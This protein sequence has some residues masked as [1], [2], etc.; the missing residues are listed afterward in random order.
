M[1][2]YLKWTGTGLALFVSAMLLLAPGTYRSP[3]NNF[4]AA[5]PA[6]TDA[7]YD[8]DD[9]IRA[10]V[11]HLDNAYQIEH[12][13][14]SNDPDASEDDFGR[15]DYITLKEQA[16]KPDLSSSTDR[17]GVYVKSDGLYIEQDDGTEVKIFDFS[18]DKVNP[19]ALS[20]IPASAME[21]SLQAA[22]VPS[23]AVM[24]Y[25]QSTVPT[26]WLECNGQAVS[27]TTYSD[28]FTA[29]GVTY[30]DGDGSTTFNVPD[31]RGYF[32]RGWSH[33]A[34]VDP[35]KASRT[36]RGDGTT[37]DNVGTK[38]SD[39]FK[40]HDHTYTASN[41]S[42]S[43]SRGSGSDHIS[44]GTRDTGNTGG[45]ETR[46]ENIYVMYCIKT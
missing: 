29:I 44:H 25:A 23:G 21:T 7:L 37:G 43:P 30:G 32:L 45:D 15:H 41:F 20:D 24:A 38:Q 40:S 6:G 8:S 27:R 17:H 4:S 12:Y 22:F 28:L 2:K 14:P 19:S 35:N 1:K 10:N 11:S 9:Y 34:S 31:Y 39:E 18:T 16:T 26:G 13:A 36:D 33:G 42:G 5:K 3:E 46:P